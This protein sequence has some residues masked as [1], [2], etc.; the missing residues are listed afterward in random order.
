MIG[1]VHPDEG[2]GQGCS[3]VPEGAQP[4]LVAVA[5]VLASQDRSTVVVPADQR[6]RDVVEVKPGQP[7]RLAD[8]LVARV[9][10]GPVG[11][12]EP[13]ELDVTGTH[14]GHSLLLV[15]QPS[16]S[17]RIQALRRTGSSDMPRTTR[18]GRYGGGSAN[19]VNADTRA[20]M[21]RSATSTS[22]RTRDAPMQ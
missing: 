18:F 6:D 3:L 12:I 21:A 20:A 10:V 8:P 17:S 9:R 2:A 16:R 4:V 11:R 22:R 15:V 14:R 5:P 1:R 13:V 19:N 7:G